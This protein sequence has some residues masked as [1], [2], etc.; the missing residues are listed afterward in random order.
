M[1]RRVIATFA[2]MACAGTCSCSLFVQGPPPDYRPERD[3]APACNRSATGTRAAD[4]VGVLWAV[5]VTAVFA[6]IGVEEGDGGAFAVAGVGAL[7][8]GA[9]L[10]ALIVS[11]DRTSRCREAVRAFRLLSSRPAVR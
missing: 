2:L 4:G 10:G 1:R 5:A 3:G 6:A 9:H 7:G 11:A 8:T